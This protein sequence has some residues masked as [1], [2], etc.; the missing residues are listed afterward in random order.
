V[1]HHLLG[2]PINIATLLICVWIARTL[3]LIVRYAD[4]YIR[5]YRSLIRWYK[6]YPRDAYAESLLLEI[7]GSDKYF[8]VYR[9]GCFNTPLAVAFKPYII[10]PEV[11]FSPDELR[12]ILLHEWKHIQDKDCITDIIVNLITFVFWWN[13]L[14]YILKRN[15]SFAMEQKSDGYAVSS[16]KEFHHLIDGLVKL[17]DFENEK[18]V[19]CMNYEVGNSLVDATSELKDRISVLILR[20]KS[21]RRR[22]FTN[23][24]YSIII[25]TLFFASY[26]ITILPAF[27]ESTDIPVSAEDFLSEYREAGGIFRPDVNFIINN[28]DGTFSL[29][30]NGQFVEYIDETYELFNWLPVYKRIYN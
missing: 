24:C 17:E 18:A 25:F 4:N 3:W 2:F 22:I 30:I 20:N 6:N 7:I 23:T 9:N 19:A 28:T 14:V 13:P 26:M 27:W 8:R 29:Y 10:L 21:R 5:R 1:S 15:F 16:R 12:V 11:D